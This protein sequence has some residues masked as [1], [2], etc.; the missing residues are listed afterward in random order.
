MNNPTRELESKWGRQE[1]RRNLE[2][3]Q[4][5]RRSGQRFPLDPPEGWEQCAQCNRSWP[6]GTHDWIKAGPHD[7]VLFCADQCAEDY[8]LDVQIDNDMRREESERKEFERW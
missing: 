3:F 1:T 5:D 7:T 8:E 4:P 2:P 6:A